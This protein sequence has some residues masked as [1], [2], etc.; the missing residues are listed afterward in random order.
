MLSPAIQ[1]GGGAVWF[2]HHRERLCL[3]IL[4]AFILPCATR[5][6]V[7]T[8][9]PETHKGLTQGTLKEALFCLS[10]EASSLAPFKTNT[11]P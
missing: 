4:R 7:P 10:S 3:C 2:P 9:C 6:L 8:L 5:L 11:S 1:H